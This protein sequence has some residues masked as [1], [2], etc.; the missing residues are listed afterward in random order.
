MVDPGTNVPQASRTALHQVQSLG[1][2]EPADPPPLLGKLGPRQQREN[3]D[4]QAE[5]PVQVQ[6]PDQ[7]NR[8]QPNGQQRQVRPGGPHRHH[9]APLGDLVGQ[10]RRHL[11]ERLAVGAG[12]VSPQCDVAVGY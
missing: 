10:R 2:S 12:V 5:H 7:S 3:E 8:D 11:L 6:E 1:E 4:Q 9:R